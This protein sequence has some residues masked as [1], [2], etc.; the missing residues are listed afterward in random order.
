MKQEHVQIQR[1]ERIAPTR[2]VMSYVYDCRK[3]PTLG[4]TFH[5]TLHY[6]RT[7]AKMP[8]NCRVC[9]HWHVHKPLLYRKLTNNS[10]IVR[11]IITLYRK[12]RSQ[13]HAA[14]RT[15][16][17]WRGPS[18]IRAPTVQHQCGAA[19]TGV[20]CCADL[21]DFTH[22]CNWFQKSPCLSRTLMKWSAESF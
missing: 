16:T 4:I 1:K 15:Y 10:V 18:I 14:I 11:I 21:P 12:Q 20:P 19:N 6:L 7:L 2:S 13:G 5:F 3:T 22:G 17:L 8:C 9:R